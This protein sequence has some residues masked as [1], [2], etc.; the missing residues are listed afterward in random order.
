MFIV[1]WIMSAMFG[2]M[3]SVDGSLFVVWYLCSLG[4]FVLGLVDLIKGGDKN[5]NY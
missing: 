2:I 1:Y 3:A 4:C 5:D